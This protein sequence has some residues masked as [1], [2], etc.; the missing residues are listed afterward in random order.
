MNRQY[1]VLQITFPFNQEKEF[2]LECLENKEKIPPVFNRNGLYLDRKSGKTWLEI[3]GEAWLY[4]NRKDFE[5]Y[6]KTCTANNRI[7]P[8]CM[9]AIKILIDNRMAPKSLKTKYF[10]ELDR[11]TARVKVVDA[12]ELIE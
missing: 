4:S 5:Y 3:D 6:L 12:L 10:L 9:K 1:K 2:Y 11:I 8:D 7:H